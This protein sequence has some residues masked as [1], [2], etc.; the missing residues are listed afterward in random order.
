LIHGF[1]DTPQTLQYLADDLHA[2]GYDVRAPL[3]PGH[4][5]TLAAFDRVTH[6]EWI[7]AVKAELMALRARYAWVALGGLS[8][9]GALAAIVAAEVDDLPALC[10]IAPYVAMPFPI[11][12]GAA[13]Y[14]LLRWY[15][16]PLAAASPQSIHD[17]QERGKNLAYGA[18]TIHAVHELAQVVTCVRRAL[19][20]VMVPTLIVQSI[21]D[22]RIAPS[23]AEWAFGRLGTERKR[24]VLTEEGGHIITVDYGRERVNRD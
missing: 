1:G 8:M 3:L 2:H 15:T 11:R 4:G 23:V 19:P 16:R 17:P 10:L 21:H 5:R 7:V 9:G 14:P 24:I 18:V 12:L 6:D 13:C 20:E 22:N